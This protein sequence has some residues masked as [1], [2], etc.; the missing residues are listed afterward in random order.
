MA[1]TDFNEIGTVMEKL[2]PICCDIDILYT[3]KQQEPL[4]VYSRKEFFVC[5]D[6]YLEMYALLRQ[7]VVL[8]RRTFQ[9]K[10]S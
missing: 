1:R 4:P 7:L 10:C 8:T 5:E 9:D 2:I 6:A 3:F